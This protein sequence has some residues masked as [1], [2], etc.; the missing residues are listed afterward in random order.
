M[1]ASSEG[2][3]R[4]STA[5]GRKLGEHGGVHTL[6][7]GQRHGL[8]IGGGPIEGVEGPLYVIATDARSNTVTVGPREQLRTAAVSVREVTL[9]R[10]GGQVDAVK[11]RYRGRRMPCRVQDQPQCR[12]AR[13]RRAGDARP[14]RAHRSR[15]DRMPVRGRCDRWLRHDRA[16]RMRI[17]AL[18]LPHDR[19][20]TDASPGA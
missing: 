10:D 6:T 5:A 13:A 2:R 11:V 8:G 3:A 15:S 9:H 1:A 12:F 17:L 7:V 16:L 18:D 19:P 4:S 20:L 14:D